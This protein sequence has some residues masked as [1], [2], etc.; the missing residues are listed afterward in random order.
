MG[1]ILKQHETIL[2]R[3]ES[4]IINRMTSIGGA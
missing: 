4:V 3:D 2:N 1:K